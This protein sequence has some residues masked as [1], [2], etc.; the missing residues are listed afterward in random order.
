MLRENISAASKLFVQFFFVSVAIKVHY[1]VGAF[2]H[3]AI[4]SD[5]GALS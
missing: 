4:A 5:G 3:P 2:R 1:R